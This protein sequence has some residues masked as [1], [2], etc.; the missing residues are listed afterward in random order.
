MKN[1]KEASSF[2]FL[3]FFVLTGIDLPAQEKTLRADAYKILSSWTY[4]DVISQYGDGI[5][6]IDTMAGQAYIAGFRYDD[7]WFDRPCEL[8]FY[9]TDVYVSRFLLRFI[10]PNNLILEEVDKKLQEVNRPGVLESNVIPDSV[11]LKRL[12]ENPDLLDSLRNVFLKE[13]V[14]RKSMFE[15][16]SLRSDSLIRTIS[17]ILGSPLREGP[18][19]HTDKDSRYFATWIKNGFSCSLKDYR[20]FTEVYF[21][22]PPAPGAAI[23]EFS[24]D[25]G[26]KLIEKFYIKVK[27]ESLE[28]SLLGIS[29][30]KSGGYYSQ[31]NL[32][33]ATRNGSLYLEELPEERQGGY[34]PKI[35]TIDLT[36]DGITDIWLQAE[37]GDNN[38]CTTN[39][40]Y[41]M[42]LIEPL[43]IFDPLEDFDLELDGEFQDNYQAMVLIAGYPRTYIPLDKNN[44]DY[45]GL[46]DP[47]GKLIKPVKLS[48]GCMQRFEAMPYTS[49]KGQQFLGYL[50]IYGLSD[51]KPIGFVQAIWDYNTG[52]W[53]LRSLEIYKD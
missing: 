29:V 13:F 50:P 44:P 43:L 48:P 38:G 3:L 12:K 25:P 21:G 14:F 40:I 17:D 35:Q 1:L 20:K 8:E 52:G 24:L 26:T 45:Q 36:G 37:T 46:Y 33:A 42:E 53:E 28:I 16:D 30:P 47:N 9:F 51:A 2:I 5:Q 7:E 6:I 31:I 10:H 4:E 19:P 41:T 34:N 15:K 18:T 49:K 39:F 23:S 22:I 32:L 11:W 27:N